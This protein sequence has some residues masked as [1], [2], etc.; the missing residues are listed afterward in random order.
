[1]EDG[2]RGKQKSTVNG[3]KNWKEKY[4]GVK[5]G[6]LFLGK[7]RKRKGKETGGKAGFKRK[8]KN[9]CGCK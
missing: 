8:R 1:M 2:N 3:R 5:E 4:K 9:R 6:A 7:E